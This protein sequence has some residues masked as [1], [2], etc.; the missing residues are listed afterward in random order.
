MV[1]KKY[2]QMLRTWSK[3]W[4]ERV[5]FGFINIAT[6]VFEPHCYRQYHCTMIVYILLCNYIYA[7]VHSTIILPLS[8]VLCLPPSLLFSMLCDHVSTVVAL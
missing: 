4:E 5:R 7:L 8:T 1:E 2:A 6:A 3:K